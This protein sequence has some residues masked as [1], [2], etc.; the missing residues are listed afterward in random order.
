[1]HLFQYQSSRQTLSQGLVEYHNANPGLVN[2]R[3]CSPEA[4]IFFKCHDAA[5]VVFG[6]GTTL[7]DEAAVKIASLFG[8]TAGAR[9]LEGYRLHESIRIYRNLG[10][11]ET[12]VTAARSIGIVPR[13][14]V[15]CARQ[16][17]RWP[18]ENFDAYLA[19][20]LH[21]IRQ[22]FGIRVAHDIR[23]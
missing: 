1:M 18:W 20:P 7:D 10:L 16:R 19:V 6:C 23:P 5:H 14:I 21:D 8:T 9:V 4:R 13:T 11:G 17:S 15:K 22:E 3:G 2:C 12:L